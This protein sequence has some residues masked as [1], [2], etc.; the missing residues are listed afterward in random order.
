M[1]DKDAMEIAIGILDV[2]AM[3]MTLNAI[4]KN[5]S[6]AAKDLLNQGVIAP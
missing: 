2:M 5:L 6:D 4:V 1:P 3:T